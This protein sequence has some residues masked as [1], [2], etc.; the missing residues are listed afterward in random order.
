M[1]QLLGKFFIN[2]PEVHGKV[3]RLLI[4]GQE[5]DITNVP[6]SPIWANNKIA[7]SVPISAPGQNSRN[8][9]YIQTSIAN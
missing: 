2:P 4:Y 5:K 8:K 1:S 3:V 6:K 7:E 9:K